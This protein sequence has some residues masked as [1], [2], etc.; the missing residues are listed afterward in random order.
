MAN[1]EDDA[2]VELGSEEEKAVLIRTL[3]RADKKIT[4]TT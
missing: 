4:L 1:E 2:I 3:K